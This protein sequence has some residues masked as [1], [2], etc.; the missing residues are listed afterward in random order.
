[1][2]RRKKTTSA[3][4]PSQ[5]LLRWY[6]RHARVL[7]WRA[8]KGRA[9]NPY[10]VAVSEF[11]LQQTGVSTVIPYFK[12]FIRR[13]PDFPALAK[14]R[15]D[16][17]RTAWAG[18]GYYR[19]AAFL[20]R[21]AQAVVKE[22]KGR[23]PQT[24][25]DLMELPGLG[26]YSA[27]AIAAIAFNE[28]AAVVDG[29]VERVVSRL[30]ALTQSGAMLR[31]AVTAKVETLVPEKRSGDFA[32]AM[33]ELGA[34]VCRP[35]NPAC[36]K[37]PLE[38]RCAARGANQPEAFPNKK[39]KAATP[40][41]HATLFIVRDGKGRLLLRKRPESGLLAGLWEFPS[42]PWQPVPPRR[43]EVRAAAPRPLVWRRGKEK[44]IH[45]FSHFRLQ[46]ALQLSHSPTTFYP[47][48]GIYRWMSWQELTK[49]ALPSV[50]RKAANAAKKEFERHDA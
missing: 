36:A 48:N 30:F 24:R 27:A 22:K 33:M 34:L 50:M 42:T 11:M 45:V 2:I 49:I 14:A 8:A 13:W 44:V 3:P 41:R 39:K 15:L 9:A 1:M 18:L 29:N 7:P 16:A 6:D 10:H 40:E 19:R 31:K 21:L 47:D 35:R 26:P 4:S 38:N 46:M 20:H 37:C 12:A 17:V 5:L 32:Q 23:L 28:P 25:E 43:Q